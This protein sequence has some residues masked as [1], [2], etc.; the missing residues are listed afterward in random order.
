MKPRQLYDL[1]LNLSRDQKGK[2]SRFLECTKRSSNPLYLLLYKRLVELREWREDSENQIRGVELLDP[3]TFYQNKELLLE[4]IILTL[5][6]PLSETPTIRFI[7]TAVEYNAIEL[8]KK[9][10]R[11]ILKIQQ[12]TEDYW[13]MLELLRLNQEQNEFYGLSLLK[14]I[15]PE[16]LEKAKMACDGDFELSEL[17]KKLK[18]FIHRDFSEWKFLGQGIMLRLAEIPLV[19]SKQRFQS[20]RIRS[21]ALLVSGESFKALQNQ[22]S[23]IN[24]YENKGISNRLWL[25]E[26]SLLIQLFGDSGQ[27]EKAHYWTMKLGSV[28]IDT[29][30]DRLLQKSLWIK[31]AMLIAD[32]FW[33]YGLSISALET[34]ENNPGIFDKSYE[35]ILLYTGALIAWGTDHWD[36]SLKLLETIRRIPKRDR[37]LITWQPY[38]LKMI[39]KQAKG[40]DMNSSYRSAR[41][42]LKRQELQ[43]P[44]LILR[45]VHEIHKSPLSLSSTAVENWINEYDE[46]V[47]IPEEKT[48]SYF[49]DFELWLKS[50]Q[51]GLNM[52]EMSRLEAL[53]AKATS[54]SISF[55]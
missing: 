21:R 1:I 14:D 26:V 23:L 55:L 13:G 49:F 31:N 38:L 20:E 18:G 54:N 40:D 22:V 10:A 15:N 27:G 34:L 11:R 25:Q 44:W 5:S 32:K 43:F 24:E 36:Q 45:I 28:P 3:T 12:S 35:A 33:R 42:F 53:K 6:E 46:V 37:P 47:R 30:Q 52:A 9:A 7:K 16:L 8:A 4:K 17:Y 41:R 48:A 29:E 19:S 51:N 2:V 50:I 39:V